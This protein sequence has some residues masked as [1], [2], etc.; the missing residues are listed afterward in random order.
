MRICWQFWLLG[1]MFSTHNESRQQ[2]AR[3][4]VFWVPSRARSTNIQRMLWRVF[5]H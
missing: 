2:L 5:V 3:R 1:P 4:L